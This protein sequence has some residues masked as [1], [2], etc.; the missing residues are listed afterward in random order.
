MS[1]E[2]APDQDIVIVGAT[3]DLAQRKLLPALYNLC[4]R[5]LLPK[6][7]RIIGYARRSITDDDFRKEA[8]DAVREFSR[9][10]M[11][12]GSWPKFV[13]RLSFVSGEKDGFAGVKQHCT[14]DHRLIYL[15]IP[16]SAFGPTIKAI[17]EAGLAEGT[18]LI[19][20]KPFGHD[21]NS[22]REL[23]N[24]IHRVFDESQVFR[25]DHYLGK[26]TVQN[27]IVFRFANSV[28][29]RVWNRD[30][31]DHVQFTVAESIGIEGRGDFYEETGALRDI[32]QNHVF[33]V[34][35]LLTMEPPSSF[36]AES[37]RD[38]KMKLFTAMRPLDTH[39]V[40]RGQYT[41]GTVGG[42]PEV[43]YLEEP[44]VHAGSKTETYAAMRVHI[45]N[46]RWAGVPFFLRTGK[47][48]PKRTSEVSIVFKRA[49]IQAFRDT[50]VDELP[51]NVLRISIQP[52]DVISFRF[53]AKQP[54]P[55]VVVD[56]VTMQF[57]YDS[58]F[59]VKSAEAY[60]RLLHDAMDGDPM[61][62]ARSD[63]VDRTW[64]VV[65][66]VIDDLP[67]VHPYEAGTWGPAAADELIAP[68][69]WQLR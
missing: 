20:E 14:Q 34:L 67:D 2:C 13:D 44:G 36:G 59:K 15:S 49:P 25:I 33:Q 64:Q 23:S 63:S 18:R 12:E 38:E 42:K 56:P 45:D 57:S 51:P 47:H 9:T 60:E 22:S 58:S 68:R 40:V 10:P 43:G 21:L 48:L 55:E 53:L 3:G 26:E 29:E 16:P 46:W 8:A 62:F 41:A 24:T 61:L 28:F 69:K 52:D 39:D 4:L 5:G 7:G 31:I 6:K 54:G 27:I 30:A 35:A 11:D 19:V 32:L 37:V 1:L 66:P 17:G 65:E 50:A